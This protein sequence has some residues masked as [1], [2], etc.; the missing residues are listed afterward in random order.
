MF[1]GLKHKPGCE[2]VGIGGIAVG[3][4]GGRGAQRGAGM[5][6]ERIRRTGRGEE[7]RTKREVI[8]NLN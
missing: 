4:G 2:G 6:E 1:L 7:A 8:T 3:I 5:T